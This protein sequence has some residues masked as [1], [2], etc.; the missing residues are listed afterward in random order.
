MSDQDGLAEPAVAAETYDREYYTHGCMGADEWRD[1]SG[2]EFS[3]LYPGTLKMAGM[4]PGWRVL[5]IGCGRGDL[6][7]TALELGASE[8]VGVDYAEAAVELARETL[9][10]HGDPPGGRIEL[11]DARRIPVEDDHFDLVMLL[12]VVEHLTPEE[13]HRS[14]TEARRSLRPG[15]RV[16]IHTMP[17]ARIYDLTYRFLRRALP[18]RAGRWPEDPRKELERTMHV[19]EQTTASLRRALREAGFPRPR[20]R[21]GS[22]VYTDFVPDAGARR[23]YGLLAKVPRLRQLGI[24]DIFASAEKA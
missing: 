6:V 18:G 1:S 2:L 13:L 24:A 8:A 9:R 4:E 3:G 14:L 16:F 22:W 7:C 23:V 20:V 15:G 19:N 10:A 21:L 11:A 12:D 17:N 5:D